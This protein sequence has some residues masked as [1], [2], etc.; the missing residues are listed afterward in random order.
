MIGFS[1]ESN[2]QVRLPALYLHLLVEI[3]DKLNC[4]TEFN[5]TSMDVK[6]DLTE[7]K[8]FFHLLSTKNLNANGQILILLSQQ[9][10]Q[11]PIS[12]NQSL[13]DE[14]NY[15]ANL[16]EYLIHFTTNLLIADQNSIRF[17]ASIIVQ[18][19]QIPNQL[20]RLTS[21]KTNICFL[22]CCILLS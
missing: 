12:L 6:N 14:L 18:L 16:R 1:S 13:F 15:Y 5:L 19:T 10:N 3:R 22:R 2:I 11:I 9:F 20:T 17:Q 21:V 7:I 8:H 4:I